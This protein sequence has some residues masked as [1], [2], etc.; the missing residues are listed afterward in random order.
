MS[1]TSQCGLHTRTLRP[2]G[3]VPLNELTSGLTGQKM[4]EMRH[5]VELTVQ[6]LLDLNNLTTHVRLSRW[7]GPN[8]EELR[9][10]TIAFARYLVDQQITLNPWSAL[11]IARM[12][13]VYFGFQEERD[14]IVAK[15]F[16]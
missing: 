11:L 10:R 12:G 1:W 5:P 6:D 8:Y 2:C 14:A 15:M 16:I 7:D 3:L 13:I 9:D 4:A